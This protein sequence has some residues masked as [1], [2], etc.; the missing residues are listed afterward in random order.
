[1]SLPVK[2]KVSIEYETLQGAEISEIGRY[3]NASAPVSGVK[4]GILYSVARLAA[5]CVTW[6]IG[7]E[8]RD[9]F[10]RVVNGDPISEVAQWR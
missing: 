6:G 9:A 8:A 5:L 2:F 7:S 4:A 10:N 3:P 1:M